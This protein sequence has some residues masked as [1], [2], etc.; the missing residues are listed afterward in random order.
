MNTAENMKDAGVGRT[1]VGKCLTECECEKKI[2]NMCE[3]E[4]I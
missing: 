1:R 3:C 2:E 4:S